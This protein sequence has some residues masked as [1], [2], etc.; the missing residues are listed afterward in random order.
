MANHY[1]SRPADGAVWWLFDRRKDASSAAAT[2]EPRSK[3]LRLPGAAGW[4][5]ASQAALSDLADGSRA[6]AKETR[7]TT[8]AAPAPNRAHCHGVNVGWS[9]RT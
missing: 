3:P 2:A 7:S 9:M 4:V 6:T 1:P 8:T 5:K